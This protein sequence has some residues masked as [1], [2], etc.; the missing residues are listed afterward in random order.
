MTSTD[1]QFSLYGDLPAGPGALE[2]GAGPGKT[3]LNDGELR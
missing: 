2:A 1:R 3:A